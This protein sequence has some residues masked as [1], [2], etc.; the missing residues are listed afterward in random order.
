MRTSRSRRNPPVSES[1]A[2]RQDLA[3]PLP[4]S[5]VGPASG[6]PATA[7]RRPSDGDEHGGHGPL[8]LGRPLPARRAAQRGRAHDP[9]HGARLCAGQAA[10]ARA[11]GFR[12]GEDRH[13]DLPRDGR[14]RPARHHRARGI[15]RCGRFLCRLRSGGARGGAGRFGLSLDDE[16]AEF[17]GDVPDPGV[18]FGRDEEAAAAQARDRGIYRLL[19]PHR[20]RCRV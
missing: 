4:G 13:R 9:R 19:R 8:R 1:P 2:Y 15:W 6:A 14:S 11:G 7:T 5:Y 12:R 16:R 3:N 17:A 10:A 18:R 20:T